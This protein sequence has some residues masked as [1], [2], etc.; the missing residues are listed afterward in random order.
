MNVMKLF[1]LLGNFWQVLQVVAGKRTDLQMVILAPFELVME[2]RTQISGL[3][4]TLTGQGL[5]L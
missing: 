5:K 2:L 4:W 3:D 1:C